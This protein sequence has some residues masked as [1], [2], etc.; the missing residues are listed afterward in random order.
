[1]N[2]L[3]TSAG[4]FNASALIKELEI[5]NDVHIF[6][7]D[8][9]ELIASK[10]L[11][12]SFIKLP[13]ANEENYKAE[14]KAACIKNKIDVVIPSSEID[15]ITLAELKSE[16]NFKIAISELSLAQT[17]QTRRPAELFLANNGFTTNT[18]D[19]I[20]E[21]MESGVLDIDHYIA[22]FAIDFS[23]NASTVVTRKIISIEEATI[24]VSEKYDNEIIRETINNLISLFIKNNGCGFFSV[25]L[26]EMH[27][28]L[29]VNRV[30]QHLT[31]TAHLGNSIG[32]NLCK[33]MITGKSNSAST[34]LPNGTRSFVYLKDRIVPAKI[35]SLKAIVFD[36]DETLFPQKPWILKKLAMLH[37]TL[38][39]EKV[40]VDK[41]VDTGL[42]LLE[43]G[44][45]SDLLDRLA[46]LFKLPSDK[47]IQTYRNLIPDTTE[48]PD[49]KPVL[50]ELR[51]QGYLIGLLT[52]NPPNSQKQKLESTGLGDYFDAIHFTKESG[53]EKPDPQGFL[54][55]RK[56][57]N[58]EANECCMVGDHLYKD[59]IGGHASGFAALCWLQRSGGI[60]N[61]DV[62]QFRRLHP[63][64]HFHR[65]ADMV[66][67]KG[68][69][70]RER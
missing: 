29:L 66:H 8:E 12:P 1:M 44:H 37:E 28:K 67:L 41:F 69:L 60:F 47:M 23:G 61:F 32:D 4:N 9:F 30:Q 22:E 33:W 56:K 14:L 7:S 21:I 5:I 49:V 17:L 42:R 50:N 55:I 27:G 38:H 62:T 58:V 35:P 43:E 6:V 18:D 10:F 51:T 11:S 70:D 16:V 63:E 3:I 68:F 57:L 54:Q 15:T 52:D 2:I 26:L 24:A 59:I 46:E 65:F 25:H 45:R 53:F 48:Y 13:D 39:F 31:S 36:L 64:I 20:V 34:V 19:D 40:T